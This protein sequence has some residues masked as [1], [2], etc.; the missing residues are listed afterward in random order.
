[1]DWKTAWDAIADIGKNYL[2][3]GRE[4]RHR[5]WM[6]MLLIVLMISAAALAGFVYRDMI[7]EYLGSF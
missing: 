7:F 3:P 6:T 5:G 2:T 4:R 1:V